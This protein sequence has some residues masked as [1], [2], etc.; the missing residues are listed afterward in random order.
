MIRPDFEKWNQSAE[1]MRRLSL[2]AEH[3]R[4]RERFQALY[5]IGTG[6]SNASQ[7]AKTIKRCKQTVLGW[8][9]GYNEAGLSGVYYQHTGGPTA[10]LSEAEKKQSLTRSSRASPKTISC[11]AMAGP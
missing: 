6:Q 5:M 4:S 10:K 3:K 1:E 7:W 8:V 2:E 11:P 9:H